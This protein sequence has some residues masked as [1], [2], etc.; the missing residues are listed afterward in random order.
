MFRKL[1]RI[2]SL[3]RKS[4]NRP[5]NT[6]PVR[7]GLE[8]LEARMMLSDIRWMNRGTNL[9]DTDGLGAVFGND[10]AAARVVIDQVIMDWESVI[11]SFNYRNVGQKGWAPH[12]YYELRVGVK[13]WQSV[14]DNV[15]TLARG[16]IEYS[17][18]D[19]KP[20]SGTLTLDD[21]AN[22]GGWYFDSNPNDD[23]E[24]SI[25]ITPFAAYSVPAMPGAPANP[26]S[27]HDLYTV[28]LHEVGHA[29]G[30]DNT[31]TLYQRVNK[32][33]FYLRFADGS[34]ATFDPDPDSV[35]TDRV[36]HPNDLM[37]PGIA[38]G[39]RR[40]ISDLDARILGEVYGYSVDLADAQQEGFIA[41]V[42]P[43]T[44]KLT[45]HGDLGTSYD[46]IRVDVFPGGYIFASVNGRVKKFD[47]SVISS[48]V[49]LGG[50][51]NDDIRI[52]A[53]AVNQ[54]LR[55]IA[56]SGIN[57]V[58][59][60]Y[61]AFNLGTIQGDVTVF[62]Q[63]GQTNVNFHDE[64]NTAA[65]NISVGHEFV[66]FSGSNAGVRYYYNNISQD[67][68]GLIL[69]GG[70]GGNTY[71]VRNLFSNTIIRLLA[72][73]GSDTVNVQ[74]T[75]ASLNVDG[76]AGLDR[77]TIGTTINVG[78]DDILGTVYV[79]NSTSYTDLVI[80]DSFN[81][82]A[83]L[84]VRVSDQDVVGLAPARIQFDPRGIRSLSVKAGSTFSGVGNIIHVL[85]TPQNR[86]KNLQVN[87]HSGHNGDIVNV[88][89][90]NSSLTVNGEGGLDTVN[91]GLAGRVQGIAGTL[92]VTNVGGFS[93]VNVN[94][95]FDAVARTMILY[96]NGTYNVISGLGSADIALRGSEI[97][98][99]SIRLGDRGNTIRIHDTPA[100]S[101][102]G[103]LTTTLRTGRGNDQVTVNG[104]T[105]GLTLN[106][107]AGTNSITV[108]SA[109]NGL[110][111]I[112]APVNVSGPVGSNTLRI[113]DSAST[114]GHDY[115]VDRDF[116]Q[117]PDK[118]RIGYQDLASLRLDA[119]T[120][121]D[122]VNVL[123]TLNPVVVDGHGGGDTVNLGLDGDMQGISGAPTIQNLGPSSQT[124]HLNN[125]ADDA[126]QTVAM[127]LEPQS[128]FYVVKGL[129]PTNVR[130][131]DVGALEISTGDGGSNFTID[132]ISRSSLDASIITGNGNDTINV[133]RYRGNLT[134]DP[135]DGLNN[136]V[137]GGAQYG[138]GNVRGL[139]TIVDGAGTESLT[140]IDTPNTTGRRF[141]ITDTL[142]SITET[143]D[144]TV[145]RDLAAYEGL[146]A[147]SL[148]TGAGND[149]FNPHSMPG[150]NGTLDG[151]GGINT[152]DYSAYVGVDSALARAA[153]LDRDLG[154][155]A[156]DNLFENYYGH[157]ERWVK[158]P[159]LQWYFILPDGR[160]YRDGAGAAL[161]PAA[162]L[163]DTLDP[164]FHQ[165]IVKLVNAQHI[166]AGGLDQ[167]PFGPLAAQLDHDL[168]LN[169]TDNLF[170]NYGGRNERWMVSGNY[171][172]DFVWY[173]ILP[174][175]ELYLWDRVPD[176]ANG[177]LVATL[178]AS[179][180]DDISKL[181]DA[182]YLF[183]RDFSR[184]LVA[185]Y[186]GEQ[187]FNDSVG[188][189]NG[190]QV[191]GVGF[192]PGKFG[193][194][195]SFD[196]NYVSVPNAPSLEPTTVSVEAW[197]NSWFTQPS[198]VYVLAKGGNGDLRSSYAL[199]TGA[200]SGLVFSV[201]DGDFTNVE[202]PEAGAGIWD[203]NW[204]HIVGTYDGASVRLYVDGTEIGGGT[205][206][207]I[208][209][210]YGLQDTED[211]SL[212]T[213]DLFIGTHPLIDGGANFVGGV[214]ELSIYSRALSSAE[215][216]S[217]FAGNPTT[218]GTGV[219]VNLQQGTATGLLGG[220]ANIQNVIGS[221]GNDII[222]GNG[223]N[224]LNGGAGRDL[225]I[226]GAFSSILN[227]G[228]DDD[229]LI[230]GTTN[231]DN[232]Q[233]A[234]QAIMAE[235]TSASDYATRVANLKNGTGGTPILN[236]TTVHSNGGGNTLSGDAGLDL[237]FA[238]LDDLD[239]LYGDPLT[240]EFVAV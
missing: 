205:P 227:G 83:R 155:Y 46:D 197:V 189:N 145:T 43:A 20:W 68:Y 97:S 90:T 140:V 108:G 231:Y 118:A 71:T 172:T 209:I 58:Y 89:S 193:S 178:D 96:N 165:D 109:T 24:F 234:L 76:V 14:P 103:N 163:V 5:R 150:V 37:N 84:N 3:T 203:G 113:N 152:L 180:H 102:P 60:S 19:G 236:A 223:G 141:N 147:Y 57:Y 69:R 133:V 25:P 135:Q 215:I 17:G 134:I 214:D 77:V 220:I 177:Q 80:D 119:G 93:T 123:R 194:A 228:D 50:S 81:H 117:R 229:I 21:D 94:N 98:A 239:T 199:Y 10:A 30:F 204:H 64:R 18:N 66:T 42:N 153:Q 164:S 139:V 110:N 202:S 120:G 67:I 173:F 138:L 167:D 115:V 169:A 41:T 171:P 105:G 206:T 188:G 184:S 26:A 174:N 40:L 27:R 12:N 116:V 56:G 211:P 34:I 51:G 107:L 142:T 195:F 198:K 2:R 54:P 59:L 88:K 1:S 128:G 196:D 15:D 32:N 36:S 78:V 212:G 238:N 48:I 161:L 166:N 127:F 154:L 38:P 53:T 222:V 111:A 122:T 13:D 187:N 104:T 4:R 175:G 65:R 183:D 28:A 216:Q 95:F 11:D 70:S 218:P 126:F 132:N 185:R 6:P 63:G 159:A 39:E 92:A 217:L 225:L 82:A 86:A 192:D 224:V 226:A 151:G 55:I 179:F 240:E 137:L 44:R 112:N 232:D 129:S 136:I 33:N 208:A 52:G 176:S 158:D 143:P 235:W 99:L 106:V 61:S 114:T 221:A 8:Q 230:G 16:G 210:A 79:S 85:N 124:L 75:F 62:E 87:L 149:V 207:N 168:N 45:V 191:G 100:G 125:W 131:K 130:F 47:Q 186:S 144:S 72:G 156:T 9:S 35:H 200:N 91:V 146:A 101:A 49:V 74:A 157:G 219:A 7:L 22:G 31:S 148:R 160:F 29:L 233:S 181:V 201:Y 73:A 237:F 182:Q 190:T 121:R 213:D 23:L 170:Y 162:N